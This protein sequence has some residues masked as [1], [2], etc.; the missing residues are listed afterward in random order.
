MNLRERQKQKVRGKKKW[1]DGETPEE[2]KF[3]LEGRKEE[4]PV[5]HF[6]LLV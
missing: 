5:N 1:M 2:R 3:V 4:R 6:S